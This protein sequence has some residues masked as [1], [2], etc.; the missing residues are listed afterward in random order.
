MIGIVLR[1]IIDRSFSRELRELEKERVRTNAKKR[2]RDEDFRL[3]LLELICEAEK[4]PALRGR[5]E[6]D[7]MLL[8]QGV[9]QSVLMQS[10]FRISVLI[11]SAGATLALAKSRNKEIF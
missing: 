11:V 10:Y 6:D 8:A 3:D 4:I 1:F 5:F 2:I 7:K 9:D